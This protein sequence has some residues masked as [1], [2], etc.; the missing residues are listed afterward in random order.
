LLGAVHTEARVLHTQQR[1]AP[2]PYFILHRKAPSAKMCFMLM[3]ERKFCV[4][5][6]SNKYKG[7][8]AMKMTQMTQ[9]THN[10]ITWSKIAS[11]A[12]RSLS[13]NS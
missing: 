3:N 13:V 6:D 5:N 8:T 1:E 2:P 11:F 4:S 12:L 10:V 9:I 7:A